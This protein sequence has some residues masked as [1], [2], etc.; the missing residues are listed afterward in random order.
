VQAAIGSINVK[1]MERL[2]LGRVRARKEDKVCGLW[3][4]AIAKYKGVE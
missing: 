4:I 3:E 1:G 2:H